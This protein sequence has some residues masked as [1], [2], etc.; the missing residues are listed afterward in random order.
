VA[1]PRCP[2]IFDDL[3][4]FTAKTL[5]IVAALQPT[6]RTKNDVSRTQ[7]TARMNCSLASDKRAPLPTR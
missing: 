6:L 5:K 3:S 4:R 1:H 7:L 2:L